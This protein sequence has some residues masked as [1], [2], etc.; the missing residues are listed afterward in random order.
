MKKSMLTVV[1]LTA[2]AAI[3]FAAC[4][5]DNNSG[6]STIGCN[7]SSGVCIEVATIEQCTGASGTPVTSCS[8][9]SSNSNGGNS[10]VL[11]CLVGGAVCTP[12][13]DKTTCDAIS[14]QIVNTCQGSD[15]F[16]LCNVS[17]LCTAYPNSAACNLV[18]GTVDPNCGGGN[19]PGNNNS[20]S[21]GGSNPGNNNSSSSGGSNPSNNNSSSSTGPK[22][23]CD[24]GYPNTA[25]GGCY[26]LDLTE[27]DCDL[28]YAEIRTSCGRTD[29]AYCNYSGI[30]GCYN[31]A[32][33][34]T[35][36]TN[37]EYDF[38]TVVLECPISKYETAFFC[39]GSRQ[40][41]NDCDR[42]GEYYTSSRA[43][44]QAGGSVVKADF[45]EAVG[46]DIYE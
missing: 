30:G 32:N 34:S 18:Q 41:P 14:G 46:A 39:F 25:G 42:I 2:I 21:S 6:P 3:F 44:V 13:T 16:V 43:C 24:Y 4:S 37:C 27:F 22:L 1:A 12:V 19:N 31:M 11:A 10:G 45:C 29:L 33:T 35:N 23:Y 28:D 5:D 9:P 17:G 40:Y 15:Q 7:L 8:V 26:P 20:S 36:K 38:G